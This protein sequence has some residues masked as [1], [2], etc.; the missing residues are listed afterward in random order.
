MS[1]ENQNKKKALL[2][3]IKLQGVQE[4]G[5]PVIVGK[6]V[7]KVSEADSEVL[8][9]DHVDC[10]RTQCDEHVIELH[11]ICSFQNWPLD[12]PILVCSPEGECCYCYCGKHRSA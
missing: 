11:E 12:K 7:Y 2:Q 5:E 9:S 8:S 3:Q 1:T 10:S 4:Q 6:T